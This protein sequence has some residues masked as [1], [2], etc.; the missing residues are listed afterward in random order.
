[1]PEVGAHQLPDCPVTGLTGAIRG[2]IAGW[3]AGT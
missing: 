1:M 2:C 3:D